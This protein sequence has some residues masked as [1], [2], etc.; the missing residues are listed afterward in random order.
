MALA[1]WSQDNRIAARICHDARQLP[2]LDSLG[3]ILPIFEIAI[4]LVRFDHVA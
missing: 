3:A 2:G 1:Q 4:V